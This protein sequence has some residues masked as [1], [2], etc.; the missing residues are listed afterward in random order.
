[1]IFIYPKVFKSFTKVSLL[2]NDEGVLSPYL[3][4]YCALWLGYLSNWDSKGANRSVMN[5]ATN[6]KKTFSKNILFNVNRRPSKIRS[7]HLY[8]T[9]WMLYFERYCRKT[10]YVIENCQDY[11]RSKD[12]KYQ[13]HPQYVNSYVHTV[14]PQSCRL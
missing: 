4:N 12:V 11:E 8:D 2:E 6:F 7:L 10:Y 9:P 3:T 13:V 14:Q 5:R 1:M